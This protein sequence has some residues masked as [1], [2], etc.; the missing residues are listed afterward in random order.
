MA[1]FRC[2]QANR[3]IEIL[4]NQ[5]A[6]PDQAFPQEVD[7]QQKFFAYTMDS[8]MKIFYGRDDVDTLSGTADTYADVWP[9]LTLC[10]W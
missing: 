1:E 3:L 5:P 6:R 8:I 9:C 2:L 4:E 10:V 7:M